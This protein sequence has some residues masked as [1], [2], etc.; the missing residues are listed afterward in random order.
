M[1][2]PKPFVTDGCSGFMSFVWRL[3]FKTATPWEGLCVDH[4][5]AYWR[6]GDKSLRLEAD[7]KLMQGVATKGHPYWACLMFVGVRLGG[8]WWLPFPSVRLVNGK[9][10]FSFDGV[11]WGW[12]WRYPR[13]K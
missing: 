10:H 3:L 8:V 11:R 2:P 7:S 4:D 1:N 12:G 6:G 5:K 9:W 13:Y